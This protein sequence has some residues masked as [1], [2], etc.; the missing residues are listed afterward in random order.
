MAQEIAQVAR[1]VGNLILPDV[2]LRCANIHMCVAA[3][4]YRAIHNTLVRLPLA[5]ISI[6]CNPMHRTVQVKIWKIVFLLTIML[7]MIPLI[8]HLLPKNVCHFNPSS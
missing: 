8:I 7:L 4:S 2:N 6:S 1:Y 5:V 3:A